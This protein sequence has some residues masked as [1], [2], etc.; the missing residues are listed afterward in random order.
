[1]NEKTAPA[2]IQIKILLLAIGLAGLAQPVL[3]ADSLRVGIFTTAL[4]EKVKVPIVVGRRFAAEARAQATGGRLSGRNVFRQLWVR[5]S[6]GRRL[7]STRRPRHRSHKDRSDQPGRVRF[8]CLADAQLSGVVSLDASL[9][10]NSRPLSGQRLRPQECGFCKHHRDR[11]GQGVREKLSFVDGSEVDR[12]IA[13]RKDSVVY[14][15]LDYWATPLETLEHRAGD[16]KDFTIFKMT[17]LLRAGIRRKACRS[18]S[19]E[20]ESGGSSMPVSCP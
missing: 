3:A 8:G 13:Y 2:T 12:L 9:P 1:M 7:P 6:A 11:K 14:G 4:L 15:K 20:T 18:S 17:A 5:D 16:C 19:S 10:G